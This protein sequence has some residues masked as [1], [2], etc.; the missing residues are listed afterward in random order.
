MKTTIHAS[1]RK[2]LKT[3]QPNLIEVELNEQDIPYF[4]HSYEGL[5]VAT[6]T[7]RNKGKAARFFVRVCLV[8]GVPSAQIIGLRRESNT[9]KEVTGQWNRQLECAIARDEQEVNA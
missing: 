1:P 8:D 5:H 4:E 6:V 2:N 3:A 9:Q 7:L